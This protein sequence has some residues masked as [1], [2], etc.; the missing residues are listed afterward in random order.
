MAKYTVR[1]TETGKKITFQWNGERP[2]TQEDMQEIFNQARQMQSSK[3]VEQQPV[4]SQSQ[5]Q[6]DFGGIM[7][8]AAKTI[9][10]Y[11][12]EALPIAGALVGGV[13]GTVA[14]PLGTLGGAGLGYAGGAQLQDVIEQYGGVTPVK[15]LGKELMETPKDILTGATMEASGGI[16]GKGLGLGLKQAGKY[17]PKLYESA[18]KG[19]P[20][21]I[22]NYEK[23]PAIKTALEEKIAP[24]QKGMLKLNDM[25]D[26]TNKKIKDLIPEKGNISIEKVYKRLDDVKDWARKSFKQPQLKKVL[27]SIDNEINEGL[28]AYKAEGKTSFGPKEAQ[29]LKQGIYKKLKDSAFGEY[30]GPEKEMDKAFARGL[31]EELVKKYPQLQQLNTKDSALINLQK[32]I[33]KTA[34]NVKGAAMS[35]PELGMGAMGA[36]VGGRGAVAP[37]MIMNRILRVPA[38][39][40]RLA[41][42]LNKAGKKTGTPI[43]EKTIG[44]PSGKAA[45]SGADVEGAIDTAMGATAKP[46]QA[47]T[48]EQMATKSYLDGDHKGALQLFQQAIRSN[49]RKADKYKIAIN[50]ILQEIKGLQ[51]KNIKLGNGV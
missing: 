35:V 46:A 38:V 29:K 39:K 14:G 37:I 2:P 18:L 6:R 22:K 33:K 34:E 30:K 13:G 23:N 25:I 32:V 7:R 16:I 44:Y 1:D 42:A 48:V 24:T 20:R 50:Q 26:E 43:L 15:S 19:I 21:S 12:K 10:P 3:L 40:A 41:F 4:D 8:G 45:V 27:D 49:P 9:S 11:T 17:A 51:S 28:K 31:K 47:L 36:S 5:P